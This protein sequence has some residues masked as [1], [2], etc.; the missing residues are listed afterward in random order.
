MLVFDCKSFKQP[1]DR[2]V[3][4]LTGRVSKGSSVTSWASQAH[5]T[6]GVVV[7]AVPFG[8]A[9]E[10]T[11]AMLQTEPKCVVVLL[12]PPNNGSFRSIFFSLRQ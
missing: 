10:S 12:N 11:P 1:S 7:S 8:A 3:Q 9:L 4:Q 5:D 6:G 2:A